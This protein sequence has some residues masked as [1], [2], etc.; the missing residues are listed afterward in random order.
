MSG[1]AAGVVLGF[2]LATIYGASFHLVLGGAAR[3]IVLYVVAAWLGF[4]LGHFVGDLLH[5]DLLKLGAVHLFS[6]SVG[7]WIALVASWW[8]GKQEEST[9]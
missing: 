2:L 4:T 1:T 3:R 7:S 5:I 9:A 8:L 6:A